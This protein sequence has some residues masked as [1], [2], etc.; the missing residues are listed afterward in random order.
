MFQTLKY[1]RDNIIGFQTQLTNYSIVK[2]IHSIFHISL[3]DVND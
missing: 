1:M 3:H 2:L